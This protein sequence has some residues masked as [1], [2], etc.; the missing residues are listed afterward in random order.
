MTREEAIKAMEDGGYKVTHVLFT[1]EEYISSLDD[2]N[3][4]LDENGYILPK[5]EFWE[6]HKGEYWNEGWSIK[7]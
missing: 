4:Y 6:N 5:Y 7:S 1:D 3:Y 2:N